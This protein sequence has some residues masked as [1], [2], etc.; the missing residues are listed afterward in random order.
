MLDFQT[1]LFFAFVIFLTLILYFNRKK[2]K[3]EPIL[4]LFNVPIIYVIMYRSK[5]GIKLMKKFSRHQ[6][7]LDVLGYISIAIGYI[8]MIFIEAFLVYGIYKSFFVTKTPVMQL[9]LP[10]KA[11]GVFYVPFINWILSIFIIA[12]IHEFAHGVFTAK[13]KLP[14]KSTGFAILGLLLPIIPAAFVEPDENKLKKQSFKKQSMIFSAGPFA[15]ILLAS[16]I[17]LILTIIPINSYY[18]TFYN[19]SVQII[20]FTNQSLVKDKIPINSTLIGFYYENKYYP[21]HLIKELTNA[22]DKFQFNKSLTI[23]YSTNN[24]N[25]SSKNT[26]T[27]NTTI[28]L[29]KEENNQEKVRLGVYVIEK[30]KLKDHYKKFSILFNFIE[31]LLMFLV[32]LFQLN[33]G[34]G[35]ANLLPLGIA[36]GGRLL[37]IL[38]YKLIKNKSLANRIYL[39]I[40]I[41][42]I[43]LIFISLSISFM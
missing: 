27:F 30:H 2:V 24:Q 40:T 25:D 29:K 5:W 12:T 38:L 16:F 33:L 8:G 20:G 18:N 10:I 22:L 31:W 19:S 26:K 42:T 39:V 36:D 1:I 41:L 14:I 7:I 35:L 43:S 3:L 4:I 13:F 6:K 32:L 15:N 37:K 28:I 23:L 9:V 17:L 11:K 21:I 34:I